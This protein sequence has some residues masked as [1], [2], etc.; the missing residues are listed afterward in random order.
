MLINCP[1]CKKEFESKSKWGDERQYCSRS[2]GNKSR[3]VSNETKAKISKS[4]NEWNDKNLD[5]L[6]NKIRICKHCGKEYKHSLEIKKFCSTEC[7]NISKSKNLSLSLKGKTGGC[8][9]GSGRSKTGYYKGIYCGSTYELAWVIYNI[10]NNIEFIRFEGFI[11]YNNTKYFPDFIIGN[12]IIEIKGKD[13]YGTMPDKIE[14][15][16]VNGY[17]IDVLYKKDLY[18]QFEWVKCNY[19]YKK[20]QELYDGYKPKYKIVCTTCN[21]EFETDNKKRQ[22]C[23]RRC[24]MFGALKIKNSFIYV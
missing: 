6:K 11:P 4:V 19:K 24:S 9:E 23:S 21:E 15:S 3:I 2:C 20:L 5:M 12:N 16:K 7:S 22:C 14:A 18:K 1:T 17:T 13:V 8:R 10:D